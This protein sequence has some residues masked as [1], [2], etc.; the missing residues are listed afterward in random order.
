MLHH[1]GPG[2]FHRAFPP[3]PRRPHTIFT[4]APCAPAA[5][6]YRNGFLLRRRITNLPTLKTT[7]TFRRTAL[8]SQ[9]TWRLGVGNGQ[10]RR[11]PKPQKR[12]DMR[13]KTA[14]GKE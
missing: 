10:A 6:D 2:P 7:A 12:N 9:N 11:H 13:S 8:F 1:H 14:L 5:C 4:V 3:C